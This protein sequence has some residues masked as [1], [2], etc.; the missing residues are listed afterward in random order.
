MAD[1]PQN[2]SNDVGIIELLNYF[3]NGFLAVLNWVKSLIKGLIDGLLQLALLIKKNIVIFIISI[4]LFVGLFFIMKENPYFKHY[5]YEMVV[6]PNFE[7]TE[8]LLSNLNS[9]DYRKGG[10]SDN[11]FINT[12]EK[13]SIEPV[14]STQEVVEM[15]YN[16]TSNDYSTNSSFKESI[17]RDTIF[18]REVPLEEYINELK[19]NDYAT[20][21]ISL[22]SKK[23]LSNE[24]IYNNVLK[25]VEDETTLNKFKNGY[26]HSLD[27]QKNNYEKSISLIDTI[28]MA[29]TNPKTETGNEVI[30]FDGGNDNS[31]VMERELLTEKRLIESEV[32]D[33]YK[34]IALNQS[35]IDVVSSPKMVVP[36]TKLKR[37]LTSFVGYGFLFALTIVLFRKLL[38]FLNQLERKESK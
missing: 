26:L 28:L 4:A 9:L 12:L 11:E 8:A 37:S 3:K 21:K 18:F 23:P 10:P 33:L 35:I 22:K 34:R 31:R 5:G 30:Q 20:F 24:E 19:P 15:Y 1:K 2:E 27:W 16:V 14:K 36:E 25:P 6:R 7:S 13:I 29:R 32:D 17:Q 38:T